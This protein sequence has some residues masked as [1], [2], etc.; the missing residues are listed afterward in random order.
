MVISDKTLINLLAIIGIYIDSVDRHIKFLSILIVVCYYASAIYFFKMISNIMSS[1]FLVFISYL[2]LN[3]LSML[4]WFSLFL[5]RTEISVIIHE[6]FH[7][8]KRYVRYDTSVLKQKITVILTSVF[9]I[10]NQLLHHFDDEKKATNHLKFWSVG[11]EIPEGYLRTIFIIIINLVSSIENLFPVFMT[12]ILCIILHK[13][14]ETL[15]LYNYFLQHH[16]CSVNKH[17]NMRLFTDFVKMVTILREMNQVL[18]YPLLLMILYSL[19]IIFVSWYDL[20]TWKDLPYSVFINVLM[21][22]SSGLLMLVIYSVCCSMITDNLNK[23]KLT[24]SKKINEYIFGL[25]ASIP[26]KAL[27]CLKRIEMEKTIYISVFGV[28]HL[29]KGFILT[30]IGS[31]FTYDLLIINIFMPQNNDDCKIICVN[32]SKEIT[33]K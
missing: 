1:H 14:A 23:I 18:R 13:W 7:Y 28:F 2:L 30:A 19:V 22:I 31:I 25:R 17:L 32:F 27:L 4:I 5:K 12:F 11:F 26:Q 15:Q 8:R 33:Q 16:L 20:L 21:H 6:L 9:F 29:T 10:L 24:A 3:I